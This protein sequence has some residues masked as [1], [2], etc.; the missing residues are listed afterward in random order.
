MNTQTTGGSFYVSTETTA[1]R[2]QALGNVYLPP[3]Q[4]HGRH[5]FKVGIDVDRI[6]YDAHYNRQPI[7]YLSDNNTLTSA[8]L[9]L[10]A[11]QNAQ[12]PC[13]RYSTFSPAP[14]VEQYNSEV[15]AYAEDRWSITNRLLVEPGVRWDWDNIVHHNNVAPRLAGTYVVDDAGTTKISAGIG[16]IYESTPIFLIARPFAGTRQDIFFSIPNSIAKCCRRRRSEPSP[17][18]QYSTSGTRA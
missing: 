8:D 14:L 5:D 16:V 6:S 1:T 2:W 4:W 17:N 11:A 18:N 3:Q 10:T 7:S 9:C 15:S 13:T 12:F